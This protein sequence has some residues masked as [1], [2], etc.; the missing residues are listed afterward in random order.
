MIKKLK[1][2]YAIASSGDDFLSPILNE[3][4][5]DIRILIR[6]TN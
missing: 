2:D 5:F 6:T 3:D 4:F 1:S